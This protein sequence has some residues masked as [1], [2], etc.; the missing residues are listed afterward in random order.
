MCASAGVC[1]GMCLRVHVSLCRC[2]HICV[3]ACACVPLQASLHV[4]VCVCCFCLCMCSCVCVHLLVCAS[5]H[6]FACVLEK[7]I[8]WD[9]PAFRLLLCSREQGVPGRGPPFGLR[10]SPGAHW[11]I[12]CRIQAAG[13]GPAPSKKKG[14]APTTS[15][16]PPCIV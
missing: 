6:V 2:L 3:S 13:K 4:C 5:M 14:N 1:T 9:P 7:S 16:P 12:W 10:V 15:S 11:F 8:G